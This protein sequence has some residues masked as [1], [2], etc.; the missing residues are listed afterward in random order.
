MQEHQS[1]YSQAPGTGTLLW[2]LPLGTEYPG[3][4][5][6]GFRSSLEGF[7]QAAVLQDKHSLGSLL[8]YKGPVWF[9]LGRDSQV[10]LKEHH[11]SCTFT[12]GAR[13]VL[14]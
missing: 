3:V 1:A 13:V 6:W 2:L 4:F 10:G 14:D 11:R 5:P 7:V 8:I 9:P 12:L